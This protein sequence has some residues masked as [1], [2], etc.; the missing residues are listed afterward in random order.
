MNR[1]LIY[2]LATVCLA[3]LVSIVTVE[4][5][6]RIF[7]V[8][9]PSFYITDSIRGYSLRPNATGL[10]NR[11]GHGHVTINKDGFRGRNYPFNAKPGVFRI[12]VLGDSF[13]E[14]L[15]V[16]ENQTFSA[17]LETLFLKKSHC[18]AI[19]PSYDKIEVLNFG[20]GGYGTGQ[21]LLTWREKAKAYNPDL[22][23]LALYPGNDFSDNEPK[24]RTDRPVF[25][26]N[27]ENILELDTSF[28][29]TS[30]YKQRN[31][32]LSKIVDRL[33]N[34]SRIIQLINEA[35]NTISSRPLFGSS[36]KKDIPLSSTASQQAWEVTLKL[37]E[38]IS[39][40][41]NKTGAKFA[42]FS[43]STPEQLWP[44]VSSRP[45]NPFGREN[46]LS[47]ILSDASIP[48]LPLGPDLQRLADSKSLVLHGFEGQ[49]PGHGHWNSQGHRLAAQVLLPWICSL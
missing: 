3:S 46:K 15:Q 43:A 9:Y 41:V 6:L 24:K 38:A 27:S 29:E 49:S 25:T 22:V 45:P 16:D 26:L 14:A 10:W 40:E 36:H 23:I 32:L 2:N 12:A 33:I 42:V 30:E 28:R 44:N 13:T 37:L 5:G 1:N 20:V 21:E 11:E 31:S 35:K 7:R 48:F 19:K 47:R 18:P 8:T 34:H 4:L 39:S 17:Q